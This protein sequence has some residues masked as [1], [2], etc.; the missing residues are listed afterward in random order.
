MP[1]HSQ[2][3]AIWPYV[4]VAIAFF[5]FGMVVGMFVRQSNASAAVK[6]A[7][8]APGVLAAVGY[9]AWTISTLV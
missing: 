8:V 1:V 4:A 3:F 9:L 7:L 2:L 6:A 5:T